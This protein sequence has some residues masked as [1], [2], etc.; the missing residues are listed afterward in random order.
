MAEASHHQWTQGALPQIL[1]TLN[2]CVDPTHRMG[3]DDAHRPATPLLCPAV[4]C[5]LHRVSSH[6]CTYTYIC[7]ATLRGSPVKTP[8][9]C[10]QRVNQH[11]AWQA[12]KHISTSQSH[13]TD[14]TLSTAHAYIND[15]ADGF[16]VSTGVWDAHTCAGVHPQQEI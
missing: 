2:G 8:S 11:S 15:G 16:V 12:G 7:I 9:G 3:C 10:Q 1:L 14:Y 13:L 5:C 4:T 6:M